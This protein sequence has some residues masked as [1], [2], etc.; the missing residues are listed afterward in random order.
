MLPVG[1]DE[2]REV[3]AAG[4]SYQGV[5]GNPDKSSFDGVSVG[6]QSLNWADVVYSAKFV[7]KLLNLHWDI[8]R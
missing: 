8:W 4:F 5:V 1:Q 3:T 7:R 6:L 2:D